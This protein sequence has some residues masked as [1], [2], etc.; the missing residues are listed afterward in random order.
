MSV[1][2]VMVVQPSAPYK[3]MS[4]LIAYAKA[5]PGKINCG[6]GGAGGPDWGSLE[7]FKM[8]TGTDIVHVPYRGLAPAVQDLLGDRSSC[9]QHDPG[10][11]RPHQSRQAARPR[12]HH[13]AQRSATLPDIPT[14]RRFR[15]GLRL[16][17]NG[18]GCRRRRHAGGCDRKD[19]QGGPRRLDRPKIKT[20]IAELGGDPMPMSPAEFGK[21]VTDETEKWAKVIKPPASRRSE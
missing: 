4:E 14:D 9:V 1:P 7:L 8:M 3:T 16:H 13:Q 19:Q 12:R 6:S 15:E 17:S 5:N 20:R 18:T 2:F 10:G 11:H 21:F